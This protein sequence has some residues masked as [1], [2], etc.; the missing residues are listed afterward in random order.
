MARI[1][2]VPHIP[3]VPLLTASKATGSCSLLFIAGL[4]VALAVGISLARPMTAGGAASAYNAANANNSYS[5]YSSYAT[6]ERFAA[7]PLRGQ[8]QSSGTLRCLEV[9][10]SSRPDDTS[11]DT[12]RECERTCAK[13]GMVSKGAIKHPRV[14]NVVTCSCCDPGTRVELAKTLPDATARCTSGQTF[15][16]LPETMVPRTMYVRDGCRGVFKWADGRTMKCESGKQGEETTCPYLDPKVNVANRLNA[17]RI[18]ENDLRKERE[19][20]AAEIASRRAQAYTASYDSVSQ[21]VTAMN[22]Q[23][24]AAYEADKAANTASANATW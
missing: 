11:S 21:G 8:V 16:M 5:S 15:G 20:E 17:Q 3:R 22:S 23:S 24:W 10:S 6:T 13:R 12:A 4:L 9:A 14:S 2:R 18:A 19:R 1:L 7:E